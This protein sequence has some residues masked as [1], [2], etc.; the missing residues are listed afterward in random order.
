MREINRRVKNQYA[1]IMLVIRE[2]GRR[3]ETM[4]DFQASIRDR[5]GALSAA[6]DLLVTTEWLGA[7][8]LDVVE[9]QLAAFAFSI[10]CRS[11]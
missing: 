7:E 9:A 2:T 4:A 8:L 6:H 5:I 11:R 1:F 3:A 10:R